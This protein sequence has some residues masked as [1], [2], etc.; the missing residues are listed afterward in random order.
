MAAITGI[1]PYADEFPM[2]SEDEING[3]S[4]SIAAVGLIHDIVITPEGLVLD[5]RN[6][7]EACKRAGTEYHTEVREGSDDDY[8]EFVIGV[9]TT[10]RRESMTV[11]I[12]A[13]SAALVLGE[14]RRKDGRW[15]GWK[16]K[17]LQNSVKSRAES[18]A[19]R[20]CGLILDVLG[21]AALREVR[22]GKS[23]NSVYERA[24]ATRESKRLERERLAKEVAEEAAAQTFVEDRD[25]ELAALVGT[26]LKSYAEAK[27]VWE[28][29]NAE[30]AA[31]IR[32]EEAMRVAARA[33]ELSAWGKACDGLLAALSW[34]ASSVPPEDTDRY[35]AVEVFIERY[36]ALGKHINKNNWKVLK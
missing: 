32:Q 2:A 10:G 16:N 8:K 15:V 30:E 35:P 1:H 14:E 20:L 3:L 23:L 4:E 26:S 25:P 21:C 7:I 11:S 31:A 19:Y 24:I 34:A 17:T 6:R 28:K 29:R 12:A 27:A 9:N 18:E 13:A 22:D 5:G 33:A 36:K